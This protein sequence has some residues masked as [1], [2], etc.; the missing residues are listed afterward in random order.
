MSTT[1]QAAAAVDTAADTLES[2]GPCEL[3]LSC[4]PSIELQLFSDVIFL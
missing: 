2:S 1:A 3:P 4:A